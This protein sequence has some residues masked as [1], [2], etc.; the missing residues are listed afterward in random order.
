MNFYR[1]DILNP[2]LFVLLFLVVIGTCLLAWAFIFGGGQWSFFHDYLCPHD[3]S[4][5]LPFVLLV[6]LGH[7]CGL[8]GLVDWSLSSMARHTIFIGTHAVLR[9]LLFDYTQISGLRINSFV[10]L[11][12]HTINAFTQ[13]H[14][15]MFDFSFSSLHKCN[16]CPHYLSDWI[17]T[18]R[19]TL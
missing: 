12:L 17:N 19:N 5:L 13:L 3:L 11:N 15:S 14:L 2:D 7:L 4:P 18:C 8:Y 1:C 9:F 10:W 6:G 16:K